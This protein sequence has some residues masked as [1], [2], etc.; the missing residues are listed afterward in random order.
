MQEQIRS[1]EVRRLASNLDTMEEVNQM[2]ML[3][4][5]ELGI[6]LMLSLPQT[7]VDEY[8]EE[9]KSEPDTDIEE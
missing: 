9:M 5:E 6:K 3:R 4:G 1:R 2:R 8:E 7:I